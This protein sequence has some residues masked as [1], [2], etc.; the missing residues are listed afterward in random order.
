MKFNFTFITLL[1]LS[2]ICSVIQAK[3]TIDLINYPKQKYELPVQVRVGDTFEVLLRE[4]P[5]T[6]FRWTIIDSLLEESNLQNILR[7][8]GS[9]FKADENRRGAVGIG[10]IRSVEFEILAPGE[11]DLYITLARPWELEKSLA[12]GHNL[13]DRYMSKVIRVRALKNLEDY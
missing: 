12:E 5:S 6:G 4:N 2:L 7:Q 10:G 1:T 9:T 3:E 13:K 8:K 11:G